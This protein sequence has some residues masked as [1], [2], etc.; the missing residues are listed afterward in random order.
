MAPPPSPF[1]RHPTGPSRWKGLA[2]LAIGGLVVL[3]I[4]GAGAMIWFLSTTRSE[5]H[6]DGRKFEYAH[7]AF[8]GL[9]EFPAEDVLEE[10]SRSIQSIQRAQRRENK[11][12][13]KSLVDGSRAFKAIRQDPATF[14][15]D[16]QLAD[17]DQFKDDLESFIAGSLFPSELMRP[18][19]TFDIRH[20]R[21]LDGQDAA[22]VYIRFID[23]QDVVL[24]YR[25]WLCRRRSN[26][27]LFDYENLEDGQRALAEYA[28]VQRCSERR[29]RAYRNALDQIIA[30]DVH[31]IEGRLDDAEEVLSGVRLDGLAPEDYVRARYYSSQARLQAGRRDFDAALKS[32]RM[33]REAYPDMLL[34][35]FFAATYANEYGD[36]PTAV[37]ACERY[38]EHLGHDWQICSEYGF[39][40]EC[41]GRQKEAYAAFRNALQCYPPAPGM[42]ES[43]A[44]LA[45]P[46]D[47]PEL[48]ECLSDQPEPNEAFQAICSACMAN[49]DPNALTAWLAAAPE[50]F[51]DPYWRGQAYLQ[52]KQ[53][54]RSLPFFIRAVSEADEAQLSDRL[55]FMLLAHNQA[56][57]PLEGYRR[58]PDREMAFDYLGTILADA[59]QPSQLEEL[60]ETH[61]Q[62][63]PGDTRL[64]FY[65]GR[66]AALRGNAADS[67][68]F[69]RKGWKSTKDADLQAAYRRWLI[70]AMC[71]SGQTK[72]ACTTIPPFRETLYQAI[73]HHAGNE[74]ANQLADVVKRLRSEYPRDPNAVIW[75]AEVH[76][77]RDEY[78]KVADLL[79]SPA[80]VRARKHSTADL[81]YFDRLIRSCLRSG[82]SKKARVTAEI[83]D[84]EFNTPYW[85]IIVS[86]ASGDAEAF[87]LC[88]RE[89]QRRGW[90]LAWLHDDPDAG[91]ALARESFVEFAREYPPTDPNGP[92]SP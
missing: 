79:S 5:P 16:L 11:A 47:M 73:G 65:R 40:L 3:G 14:G 74:D 81:H 18:W 54:D 35:E 48:V 12:Q 17:A 8:T 66:L 57:Q 88:V 30:A 37:D 44:R 29:V 51:R 60:I 85:R 92:P 38:I 36:Y 20:V 56:G 69:F 15:S 52:K 25:F 27:K 24:K 41:L 62:E 31:T 84:D 43:V 82:R 4:V 58:S 83:Y 46:A 13:M 67:A 77:L 68:R 71:E 2:V 89:Y 32:C 91:P 9:G 70:W 28:F 6:F 86:A 33:V 22:E 26:W 64:D 80:G 61:R 49:P 45:R 78:K 90:E 42:L 87:S 55:Y 21:M 76:W 75:Q 19:K 50:K 23:E 72:E 63:N 34:A 1:D 59:N 53:V 7:R 39:A 10:I